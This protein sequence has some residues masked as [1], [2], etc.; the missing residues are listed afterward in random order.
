MARLRKEAPILNEVDVAMVEELVEPA[1]KLLE[2]LLELL[3][4]LP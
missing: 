4:F 1:M 3:L 2:L